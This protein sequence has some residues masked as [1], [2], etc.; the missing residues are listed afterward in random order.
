MQRSSDKATHEAGAARSEYLDGLP[1]A[2]QARIL[3][4]AETVGPLPTDPDWLIAYAA[5]R[6]A[7]RIEAAV[8]SL[9][10]RA[11]GG[12]AKRRRTVSTSLC[13]GPL[14]DLAVFALALASFGAV[15]WGVDRAPG[16]AQSVILY[17]GAIVLGV[18]VSTGY[19]W[20]SNVL[21]SKPKT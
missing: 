21:P 7:A 16:R 8:A 15:A 1:P 14:R 5:D 9:E 10:M 11:A 6:A 12:A 3:R 4:H 2:E 20:L 17:I 19:V 18:S 13:H